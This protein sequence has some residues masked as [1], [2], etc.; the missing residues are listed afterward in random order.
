MILFY[1]VK[2]AGHKSGTRRNDH[3][4]GDHLV[5]LKGRPKNLILL[6]FFI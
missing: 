4:I 5:T 6:S 1:G 3:K 2:N